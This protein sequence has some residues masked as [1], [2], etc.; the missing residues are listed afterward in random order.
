VASSDEILGALAKQS[1][2]SVDPQQKAAWLWI[3]AQLQTVL[4]KLPDAHVFIEFVIPRMGRRVDAIVI[5]R[6]L[7]FVLEYK[8]GETSFTSSALD[9]TLG[10]A[11]DPKNFHETSHHRTIVPILKA[12]NAPP[13]EVAYNCFADGVVEPLCTN[14]AELERVI[15]GCAQRWP[16]D[17]LNALDWARG[18][19]KPTPTII[20]AA[21]ALYRKHDVQ[22]ISRSEAGAENLTVTAQYIG[23]VIDDAKAKGR[24]TICFLTGVP[25]SGKTLAGLNVANQRMNAH[26]DEH[27][28]FLSGNGPLVEVLRVAL[29]QDALRQPRS[30]GA[31]KPT[32]IAEEKKAAAFIQNIHHFR[33][34]NLASDRPPVEKVVVFDEAQRAWNVEQTSRFMREK[35]GQAGF[36]M[37]EPAFLLSVMDRHD[38]W[39]CVICLVGE[40]QEINSGEVG[41]TEWFDAL[42][43]RFPDWRVH[44]S[45][46]VASQ[47]EAAKALMMSGQAS[48]PP[49]P[50]AGSRSTS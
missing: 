7:V 39:C 27:A 37:S 6:G 30:E 17:A 10:Y 41:I 12:T 14:G 29:A 15:D 26:G 44:L 48:T 21:Q 36:N 35:R 9:Q 50:W 22:E 1:S 46:I 3:I 32:R 47:S 23:A 34:D 43:S 33:D 13:L 2:F 40:G 24:K 20:E 38:D 42:H 31:P 18:R 8:V 19:Y 45:E 28:V 4:A 25:G 49:A 11:L 5:H 16:A